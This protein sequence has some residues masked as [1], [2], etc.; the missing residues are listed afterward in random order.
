MNANNA[1]STHRYVQRQTLARTVRR[2]RPRVHR[3]WWFRFCS[4]VPGPSV[5]NDRPAVF[6]SEQHPSEE[7]PFPLH[8]NMPHRS[9]MLRH[10]S[11]VLMCRVLLQTAIDKNNVQIV[12]TAVVDQLKQKA[13][14][15]SGL[16]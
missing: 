4:A 2:S 6:S 11:L 9:D 3:R 16:K 1:K 12:F 10:I 15:R 13:L 8:G 14:A 7:N 5:P